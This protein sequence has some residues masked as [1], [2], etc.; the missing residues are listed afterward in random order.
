V[1]KENYMLNLIFND[2]LE[3]LICY[4]SRFLIEIFQKARNIIIF[5]IL[6]KNRYAQDIYE[7]EYRRRYDWHTHIRQFGDHLLWK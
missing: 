5:I 3:D 6:A 4:Q 2:I 1:V 7:T